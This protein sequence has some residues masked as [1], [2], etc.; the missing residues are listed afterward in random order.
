MLNSSIG[1][2]RIPGWDEQ[3]VRAE[4]NIRIQEDA[5]GARSFKFLTLADA[6]GAI[7]YLD[8][9]PMARTHPI[10]VKRSKWEVGIASDLFKVTKSL[11]QNKL[12]HWGVYIRN[13]AETP[14]LVM[15]GDMLWILL[16]SLLSN[17]S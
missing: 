11:G 3:D 8:Y 10:V 17:M 9:V 5:Q 6:T 15:V 16:L 4:F 12:A 1:L 13:I 2:L 7:K 14:E